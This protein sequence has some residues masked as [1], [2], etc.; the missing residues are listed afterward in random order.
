MKQNK[1]KFIK[2]M[3]VKCLQ[4]AGPQQDP[5]VLFKVLGKGLRKKVHSI[6]EGEATGG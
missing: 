1:K 4:R 3:Q 6:Q 5:W 2:M